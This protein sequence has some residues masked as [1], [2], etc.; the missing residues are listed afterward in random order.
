MTWIDEYAFDLDEEALFVRDTARGFADRDIA[1]LSVKIDREH[2]FPTELIPKLA[3]LG[4]LGALVPE[5]F[6]GTALPQTTYCL[7]VEELAAK[8]A[9]TSIIVSAHNSLC[10]APIAAFGNDEQKKEFLPSLADGSALG[11][12][13]LSEPGSGSDA[14]TMTCASRKVDGGYVVS[15]TKNWITNGPEA[16][17]CVLF[18]IQDRSKG[19][20]GVTAFVIPLSLP[21]IS[22][23]V[24]ED[25]LGICGSPT[26]SIAFQEVFIPEKYRL[27]SEGEGF[28][29][30][31]HTLNGGR[32]GVAAQAIGIARAALSDALAYSKERVAFGKPICQHQSIQNYL[33]EMVTDIDAAR[34]LTL[35]AAKRKDQGKKFIR[36]AAQAKL[37][38]SRV[39]VRSA[40]LGV[41]I[42]GG[43]GYVKDYPAERHLRD[44]KITEIY[45]GTS[46]IQRLV[47]AGQLIEESS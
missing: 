44:A 35:G 36:Q 39:A 45:E 25:K 23:G 47:V 1:P 11:C 28:R 26:S 6:G 12:F 15:G 13:A 34:Y 30:A 2:Y 40:D 19:Y 43:Y 31:M 10:V 17:T 5:E 41:Q 38:A 29:L 46:E 8:C 37:S 42:F 18:T 32:I 3:E 14:A 24:R 27:G 7:L 33:A 20:K 9:S 4:F 16:S 22:I 21:G